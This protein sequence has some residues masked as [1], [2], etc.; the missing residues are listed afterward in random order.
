MAIM[1]TIRRAFLIIAAL[2]ALPAVADDAQDA[3]RFDENARRAVQVLEAGGVKK[4]AQ[5]DKGFSRVDLTLT[6]SPSIDV[7]R[8]DSVLEPVRATVEIPLAMSILG[9]VASRDD[10]QAG[11]PRQAETGRLQAVYLPQ[12]GGWRLRSAR[13]WWNGV[14]AWMPASGEGTAEIAQ[15]F[16][17]QAPAL[18]S[19]KRQAS[20]R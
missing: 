13:V 11:K 1:L 9:P 15:M 17:V 3:R 18:A 5:S 12:D 16:E 8:T 14:G 7:K 10:A 4:I 6:G 2:S 19:V 20:A